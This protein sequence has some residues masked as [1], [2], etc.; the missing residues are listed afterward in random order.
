MGLREMLVSMF[1]L[2]SQF[3]GK[4]KRER[5]AE[6]SKVGPLRPPLT[7]PALFFTHLL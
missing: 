7:L 3:V 5:K 4:S 6:E 2:T 1:F